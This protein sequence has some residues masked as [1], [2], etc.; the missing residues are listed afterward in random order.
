[1]NIRENLVDAMIHIPPEQMK[2]LSFSE[3]S[4]YGLNRDDPVFEE[5]KDDVLAKRFG[6][7]KFEYLR[8]KTLVNQRC[9]NARNPDACMSSVMSK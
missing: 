8:R 7:S 1:M 3:L 6:L 9:A 4:Y 2:V 5:M